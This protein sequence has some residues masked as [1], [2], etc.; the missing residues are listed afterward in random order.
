LPELEKPGNYGCNKSTRKYYKKKHKL[1]RTYPKRKAYKNTRKKYF[2]KR[3][4][5]PRKYC[6]KGKKKCVCWICNVEGH[7]ADE[8]PTKKEKDLKEKSKL[9]KKV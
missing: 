5:T 9:I 1:R 3:R 4:Q 7:Y 6:P 8:C 2:R